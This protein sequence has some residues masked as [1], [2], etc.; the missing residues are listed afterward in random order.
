MRGELTPALVSMLEALNLRTE[1]M[2]TGPILVGVFRDQ[3]ELNGALQALSD[4][5]IEL[6]SVRQ[7]DG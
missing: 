6:V 4:L 1:Q 7:L 2:E 5:G 3:A